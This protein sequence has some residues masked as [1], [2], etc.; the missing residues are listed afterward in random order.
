M[1]VLIMIIHFCFA[2]SIFSQKCAKV[3]REQPKVNCA[4]NKLDKKLHMLNVYLAREI[5][6][7][8][9]EKQEIGLKEQTKFEI[10]FGVMCIC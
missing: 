2:N 6:L 8:E 9:Q 10:L 1:T 3:E 4:S 7:E 5:K